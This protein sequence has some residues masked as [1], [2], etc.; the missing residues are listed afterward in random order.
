MVRSFFAPQITGGG[1]GYHRVSGSSGSSSK[2]K[3]KSSSSSRSSS[4][5]SSS[6]SSSYSPGSG[7]GTNPFSFPPQG[8]YSSPYSFGTGLNPSPTPPQIGAPPL[9]SQRMSSPRSTSVPVGSQQM[10]SPR[11]NNPPVGSQ[12]MSSP[13]VDPR[14]VG[15][16]RMS[17][18]IP[19]KDG[20]I[21]SRSEPLPV[22]Q[23]DDGVVRKDGAIVMRSEP[24]PQPV[25]EQGAP[26][27]G[28]APGGPFPV[29]PAQQAGVASYVVRPGDTLS[30]IANQ[31]GTTVQDLARVN[32]IRNPNLIYPDQELTIPQGS[33][34][35]PVNNFERAQEGFN[36]IRDT[37][38]VNVL[39]NQDNT[40]FEEAVNLSWTE[41]Q[42]TT[43]RETEDVGALIAQA[44]KDYGV[45]TNGIAGNDTLTKLQGEI[46]DGYERL[47]DLK[48]QKENL[49]REIVEQGGGNISRALLTAMVAQKGAYITQEINTVLAEIEGRQRNFDNHVTLIK[50]G[51][52]EGAL[53]FVGV[54]EIAPGVHRA[55]YRVGGQVFAAKV[56]GLGDLPAGAT[57]EGFSDV[58][59]FGNE[60]FQLKR[61]S[62]GDVTPTSIAT[63]PQSASTPGFGDV[64]QFGD[65]LYRLVRNQDGSVGYELIDNKSKNQPARKFNVEN[66]IKRIGTATAQ[67]NDSEEVQAVDAWSEKWE[68]YAQSLGFDILQ[69]NYFSR[70]AGGRE[71]EDKE[72]QE[73]D[74]FVRYLAES[75]N[76]LN[77]DPQV[78]Q[79]HENI[80]FELANILGRLQG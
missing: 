1:T 69:F 18:P 45:E 77:E 21:V 12:Q 79:Y 70:F 26:Q 53:D 80:L 31:Y 16:Q 59:S 5:R 13:R 11:A 33:V 41:S 56:T 64:R 72:L 32:N 49:R 36:N 78:R 52:G 54:K 57:K 46:D 6:S 63:K 42:A 50:A 65:N 44:L 58:R 24:V 75:M 8:S 35:P 38:V 29:N 28:V 39:P 68:D 74:G 73:I 34:A 27:P 7:S 23:Q 22:N 17:S 55:L 20:A 30:K 15:S 14:F 61:D 2:K 47:A 10:S 71:V 66:L 48:N 67:P 3:K 62:K 60:L 25:Q 37:G 9:G 43:A 40:A 4:T 76:N 51:V 19:R